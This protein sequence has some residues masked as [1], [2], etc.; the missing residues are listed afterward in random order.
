VQLAR[1]AAFAI[2]GDDPSMAEYADLADELELLLP[3]EGEE[4]L[5]KS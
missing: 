5:F 2:V 3:T 4:F 1:D